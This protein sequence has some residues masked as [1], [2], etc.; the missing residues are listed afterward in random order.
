MPLRITK[1]L[2]AFALKSPL[3]RRIDSKLYALEMCAKRS[4]GLLIATMS[5]PFNLRTL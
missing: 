2:M 1:S 3:L 5:N 4:F